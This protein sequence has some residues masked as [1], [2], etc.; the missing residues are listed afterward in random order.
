[1]LITNILDFEKRWN[2][3]VDAL[4]GAIKVL[5]HP[6]EYGAISSS[7]FPYVSILPVFAALRVQAKSLPAAR[8]LDA[9][10]K[11]RHWY[12]ASVFNNRYSGSVESTSARDFIDLK[13][14]FEDDTVEP[15]LIGEFAQRFRSLDLRKEVKR[16]T[17]VYNGIFNLLVLQGARDWM[18][19]DVPQYGDL[20]DHHIVPDLW[21][22]NTLKVD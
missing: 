16:G 13:A 10:R 1:M 17:S 4:E 3:A 9:R 8:Q 12:W 15:S 7:F 14:W 20:D 21:V 6:Q 22:K 18:T 11:L 2:E 19:G 5:M